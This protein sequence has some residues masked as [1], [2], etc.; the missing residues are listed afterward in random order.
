M[1]RTRGGLR[2]SGKCDLPSTQPHHSELGLPHTLISTEAY[3]GSTEKGGP[4]SNS[5]YLPYYSVTGDK[6]HYISSSIC[7]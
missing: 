3:V 2:S 7:Q 1:A 4:P 6:P 5:S